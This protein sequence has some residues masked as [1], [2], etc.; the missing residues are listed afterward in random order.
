MSNV[1]YIPKPK[2]PL[3]LVSTNNG[4]FSFLKERGISQKTI[5]HFNV[6]ECNK[7]FPKHGEQPLSGILTKRMAKIM[8][9]SI[10]ARHINLLHKMVE[11]RIV[12]LGYSILKKMQKKYVLLRAS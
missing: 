5:D 8:L 3:K 9:L 12:S 4:A 10:D 7:Y 6:F 1:T 2:T 11:G